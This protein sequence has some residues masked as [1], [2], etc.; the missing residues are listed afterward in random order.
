M[1]D[2]QEKYM[3]GM[4]EL[5]KYVEDPSYGDDTI[6]KYAAEKKEKE[7]KA[8]NASIQKWRGL[9]L[10]E[11]AKIDLSNGIID[12]FD[13][14]A[15]VFFMNNNTI[16]SAKIKEIR[17]V[18]SDYLKSVQYCVTPQKGKDI[19]IEHDA[20]FA[21][22]EEIKEHLKLGIVN[23]KGYGD[24]YAKSDF[25]TSLES[26]KASRYSV[27][28]FLIDKLGTLKWF[29]YDNTYTE[30]PITTIVIDIKSAKTDITYGFDFD[31]NK[32]DFRDIQLFDT[33]EE[34][35]DSL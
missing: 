2:Y 34:L 11:Y 24:G 6:F 21:S 30:K 14:G 27:K 17:I 18:I 9:S 29:I 31:G 8:W 26:L 35:I 4:Q 32:I 16:C 13:I 33:K 19:Y 23:S 20:T 25:K 22:K 3:R 10:E 1:E 12:L 28:E 15:E 7:E 5:F